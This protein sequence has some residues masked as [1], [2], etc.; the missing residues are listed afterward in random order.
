M[1]QPAH[2]AAWQADRRYQ[3]RE[4]V[5]Q[6]IRRLDGRGV[7]ISFAVVADE[8]G[9]DRSWLYSQQDLAVEIRRL[10][11]ETAGP[12]V[13]R[14]WQERASEASLRARLGA[15]QQ[16][17]SHIR[18]E[19]T[20]LRAQISDLYAELARIRGASWADAE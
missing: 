11:E 14:P 8:A 9:V 5:K 19:N 4:A 15:A 18:K 10:R 3:K 6:A 13:V 17:I 2:L 1:T 7:A 20:G 16:T 12:M